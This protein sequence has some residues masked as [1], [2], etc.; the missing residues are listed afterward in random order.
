MVDHA[1]ERYVTE[2]SLLTREEVAAQLGVSPRTVARLAL[3]SGDLP[4]VRIGRLAR[5]R[6]EDV[7]ALI[8]R[9]LDD[10]RPVGSPGAVPT[11]ASEGGGHDAGYSDS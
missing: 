10:E 8:E 11:S 3:E 5:F 6:P 4:T 9:R 7:T 1:G 2:R